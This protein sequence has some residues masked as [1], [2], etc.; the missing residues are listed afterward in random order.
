[1]GIESRW[2]VVCQ[3]ILLPLFPSKTIDVVVETKD[4][5]SEQERLRDIHESATC[6]VVDVNDLVNGNGDTA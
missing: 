4:R 1:M 2:G 6:H 3:D 5:A